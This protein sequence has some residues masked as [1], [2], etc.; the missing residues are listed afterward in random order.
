MTTFRWDSSSV[1]VKSLPATSDRPH[2][3]QVVIADHAH[4]RY[5]TVLSVVHAPSPIEPHRKYVGEP[6][7]FDTR[8]RSDSAQCLIKVGCHERRRAEPCLRIDSQR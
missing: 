5:C 4:V 6:D 7:G 1:A 8:L 3:A 2:R